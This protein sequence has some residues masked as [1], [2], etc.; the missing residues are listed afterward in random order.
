MVETLHLCTR[1]FSEATDLIDFLGRIR[2]IKA[3]VMYGPDDGMNFEP[4][5]DYCRERGV[6]SVLNKYDMQPLL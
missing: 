5:V 3:I 2:M 4:V 6:E 1:D